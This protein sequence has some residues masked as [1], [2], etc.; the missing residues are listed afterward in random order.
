[1]DCRRSIC[2]CLTA[3][4]TTIEASTIDARTQELADA[5]VHKRHDFI[6]GY[7][8]K[9]PDPI[10][11]VMCSLS[12]PRPSELAALFSVTEGREPHPD[13]LEAIIETGLAKR[14][15]VGTGDQ[16]SIFVNKPSLEIVGLYTRSPQMTTGDVLAPMST[17]RDLKNRPGELSFSLL[18]FSDGA[19]ERE[20][21]I[22]EIFA[23]YRVMSSRGRV[24]QN[25]KRHQTAAHCGSGTSGGA[26]NAVRDYWVVYA[27]FCG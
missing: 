26:W 15:G 3:S 4:S 8:V 5:G 16:L 18:E 7:F 10:P 14:W 25:G 21:I 27:V 12:T 23:D 9:D 22:Q 11:L 19:L 6:C 1:M 2:S 24:S 13:T 17:V 20:A